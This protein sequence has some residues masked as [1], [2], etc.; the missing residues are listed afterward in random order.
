MVKDNAFLVNLHDMK[1]AAGHILSLI[2]LFLLTFSLYGQPIT[3]KNPDQGERLTRYE[4]LC[5]ECLD[6]KSM[7]AEGRLVSRA[8]ASD[9]INEFVAM[10]RQIR[11]S[12][13]LMTPMQRARFEMINHWF[14][15]GARPLA[16]DHPHTLKAI[17]PEP[18]GTAQQ[19]NITQMGLLI[20][21][22]AT[23]L[24]PDIRTGNSSKILTYVM[25]DISIPLSYGLMIGLQKG[26]MDKQKGLN[27][28]GYMR[29]RSNF[30][31]TKPS[32]SCSGDGTIDDNSAFW[33]NG[34]SRNT[35]ILATTGV[36]T[37]LT[38]WLDIYAGAGYGKSSLLWQDIDGSWACVSNFTHEGMALETGLITSWRRFCL[39]IGISTVNFRTASLDLS[40][41][42]YF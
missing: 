26:R 25:A 17:S 15:T 23:P 1:T 33:G 4:L 34:K 14:S 11:E 10:N 32:Y 18:Q 37:G 16:M 24:D 35:D 22:A 40:V 39:G 20:P 27:W 30:D 8:Y 31:F 42:V 9:K 5:Q 21:S 13:D 41:G 36:L 7:V 29:L 12:S 2:F 3:E 38:S 28:G 6:L 19:S